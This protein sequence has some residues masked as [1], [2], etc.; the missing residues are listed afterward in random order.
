MVKAIAADSNI[1]RPNTLI[2]PNLAGTWKP[3]EYVNQFL[4]LEEDID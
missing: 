1:P 3:E 4:R 2:G